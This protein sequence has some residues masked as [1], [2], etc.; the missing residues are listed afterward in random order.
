MIPGKWLLFYLEFSGILV[1][2]NMTFKLATILL[3]SLFYIIMGLKH[4]FD[5]KY[6][7][8]MIPPFIPHKKLLIYISGFLE[9]IL[10]IFL[11]IEDI[12]FY[13]AVGIIFLLIGVFPANIYVAISDEARKKL[14]VSKFFSIVR[15]FFQLPLIWLAYWHAI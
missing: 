10:G 9:I 15:L 14:K 13:A 11:L 4:I 2:K 6:F 3:L 7:F 5:P 8:P 1:L 12:R